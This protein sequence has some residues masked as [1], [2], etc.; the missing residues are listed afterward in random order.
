M[1]KVYLI[2]I[3]TIFL[4]NCDKPKDTNNTKTHIHCDNLITDTTGTNDTAR[5]YMP[6]AF[7]PDGNG[8]NDVFI[9]LLLNISFID[10]TIYDD[11]NNILFVTT[12]VG[13]GWAPASLISTNTKYYY[14][15]QAT[16]TSNHKIGICGELNS[17]KCLPTGTFLSNFIFPDQL[18]PNGLLYPTNENI[19]NCP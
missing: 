1:N 5:I 16:T 10:F 9:P 11:L 6:N 14:R 17:L 7:T 3:M 15:I 12:Q 18:S 13:Q 19:L 2:L 8:V 4:L